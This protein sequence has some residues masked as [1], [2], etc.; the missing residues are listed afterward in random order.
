MFLRPT[1]YYNSEDDGPRFP[2][3]VEPR[4]PPAQGSP[5]VDERYQDD[6]EALSDAGSSG[7]AS[8]EWEEIMARPRL[9]MNAPAEDHDCFSDEDDEDESDRGESDEDDYSN[10]VLDMDGGEAIRFLRALPQK[11]IEHIHTLA[12]TGSQLMGDDGPS[13]RAW[14][15][16]IR[17]SRIVGPVRMH[18]PFGELLA[19]VPKL[20]QVDLYTPYGGNEDFYCTWGPVEIQTLLAYGHLRFPNLVF[21]GEDTVEALQKST[22][23]ECYDRLMECFEDSF[24]TH[25]FELEYLRPR[26]GTMMTTAL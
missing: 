24:A 25:E 3:D 9:D 1:R 12:I 20:T 13:R 21:F 15:G 4:Y 2:E 11:G 14:S 18:T 10:I 16:D 26:A 8:D 23:E 17:R 6:E 22:L 5:T 19:H 7:M